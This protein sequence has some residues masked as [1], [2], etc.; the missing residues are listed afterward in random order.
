MTIL[1]FG[2]DP[3]IKQMLQPAR[4]VFYGYLVRALQQE[5]VRNHFNQTSDTT[6]VLH[7]GEGL[8]PEPEMYENP[9]QG[10]H[11]S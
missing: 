7:H 10:I 4:E 5:D 11:K 6:R 1:W 3:T 9:L 8:S 2:L